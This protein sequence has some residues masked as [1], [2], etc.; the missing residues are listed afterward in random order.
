MTDVAGTLP[1]SHARSAAF[2]AGAAKPLDVVDR[3]LTDS[4]G[5]TLAEPL[6]TLTDM[7]AFPTSS[8]DGWAVRGGAPWRIVGRVLAGSIAEPLRQDGTCVEIATGAMVPEG[9]EAILRVEESAVTGDL[10]DGVPRADAEWRSP[11]DEAWRGEELLPAGVP[12]TPGVIGL[13]AASGYDHLRVHRRATAAMVVF[14]DELLTD[15]LPAAGRVRDSLGPQVPGWLNRLGCEVREV[16]GPVEDTLDSHVAAIQA[17][18]DTNADLVVTTGGTMHGPVDHLHPALEAVGARYVVNTVAVR[19][20]FPMLLASAERPDG[21]ATFIAGLPGNPQSAVVALMSLVAPVLA[22]LRGMPAPPLS[23]VTLGA[24]VPG[25]GDFTHLA[26]VRTG[27]DGLAVP[28]GHVGS[29]ML[30]GLA[31]AAGFAVIAPGTKGEAGD[32]V[33]LVAL[34]VLAGEAV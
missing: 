29:A 12:V 24:P 17:G 26:L 18:L 6:R 1:W 5:T 21:R 27:P 20:G 16:R 30:R 7:P 28:V 22:G 15:G 32:R 11:G 14:G 19:P 23:A 33:P 3:A 13:A 10:V 25:R 9:A 31:Q 8:I 4:D 34:P 2:Q